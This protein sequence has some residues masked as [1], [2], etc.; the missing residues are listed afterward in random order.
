MQIDDTALFKLNMH[1]L[2]IFHVLYIHVNIGFTDNTPICTPIENSIHLQQKSDVSRQ[3]GIL[4]TV[5]FLLTARMTEIHSAYICIS[6]LFRCIL[7]ENGHFTILSQFF[8]V[9]PYVKFPNFLI[10]YF[11]TIFFSL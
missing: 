4:A 9:K 3:T 11:L 10:S 2:Y 7:N 5:F 6:H 8:F 1:A